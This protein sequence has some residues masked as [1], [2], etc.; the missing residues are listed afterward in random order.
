MH[1]IYACNIY[2]YTHMCVY[3]ADTRVIFAFG[4]KW[5]SECAPAL[6]L[7]HSRQAY[8]VVI[9]LCTKRTACKLIARKQT[10]SLKCCDQ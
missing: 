9:E 10:N 8:N 3:I 5:P 2:I 7:S 1:F 6:L 4:R